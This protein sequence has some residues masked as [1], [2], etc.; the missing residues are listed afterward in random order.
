VL[1]F[2]QESR[3]PPFEIQLHAVHRWL[4]EEYSAIFAFAVHQDRSF[5]KIHMLQS[6]V[7]QFADTTACGIKQFKNRSVPWILRSIY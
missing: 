6:D 3:S 1:A 2:K 4:A 5:G 7:N